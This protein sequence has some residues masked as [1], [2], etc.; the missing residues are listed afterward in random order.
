MVGNGIDDAEPVAY[1]CFNPRPC[2]RG[3]SVSPPTPR[4]PWRFN[5]RPCMRGD[6]PTAIVDLL[7]S[8]YC[9]PIVGQYVSMP[10]AGDRTGS[11]ESPIV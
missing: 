4:S 8:A 5:P 11:A 9:P 10:T 6:L 7:L 1:I 2:M 3:D